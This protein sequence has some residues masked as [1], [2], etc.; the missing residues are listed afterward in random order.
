MSDGNLFG[1]IDL[2]QLAVYAFFLFFIGLVF[3]LR[4]EDRREGYPVEDSE[5]GQVMTEGDPITTASPKKFKLPF[6]RGVKMAPDNKR[7][8][9]EVDARRNFG[10]PGAPY[11][12]NGDPMK[13]G[14]GPGAYAQRDPVPDLD[15]EGRNRI[16]PN[17]LATDIT[18]AREDKDPR[19]MNV[20][21]CDGTIAGKVSELWVDRS[22]HQLRYLEV[23]LGSGRNVLVPMMMAK[24]HKGHIDVSAVTAA[25]F[26][27]A[28]ATA[29]PDMIT[30]LEEDQIM[31]YFGG[32]YLYATAD[33]A[34]P[35]I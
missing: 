23:A 31:G 21:G 13:S 6:D 24:V 3:Y 4:R 1:P 34:E 32:G 5:T 33:R 16:V 19:G 29:S 2:A 28:P 9:L 18:V 20:Y 7:D 8:A 14:M 11:V 10:S 35:L 15:W 26:D 27:G 12:P 17:R 25:Q 30:R 22:E